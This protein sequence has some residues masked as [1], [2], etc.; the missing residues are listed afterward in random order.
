MSQHAPRTA[1]IGGGLA[2]MAAAVALTQHGLAVELFEARR[3][4][5]GRATS[6]HDAGAAEVVDHC[7]HVSMGCCTNLRDFCRRVGIDPLLRRDET[8]SFIAPDGRQYRFAATPGIPAPLHLAQGLWKLGYLSRAER[9]SIGRALLD[10]ARE[11][12]TRDD[13]PTIGDW[14][15]RHGQT[16][17]AI[18]QFWSLVLVS[19]LSETVDRAGL[20]YAR[21]VFVDGMMAHREGYTIEVPTVALD[22]LYGDSLLAW[23]ARHGARAR[24]ECP[25]TQINPA[26]D[27]RIALTMKGGAPESFDYVVLAT[28]W[29]RAAE[30]L[31]DIE[32]LAPVMAAIS[33]LEAAPITGVHLWFDRPITTL[34]HAVLVGRL[35]QWLF[36]RA[37]HAS[38]DS[39]TKSRE[40]GGHYYQVVISASRALKQ[41][42]RDTTLSQVVKDLREVFPAAREARLLRQ[43]LVTEREAVF[44][45]LPGVDRLRPAQQT[46]VDNLFLAGD[47]TATG[48]PA[49]MEGA[50][51][52]G[53]LAAE[54]L[55]ARLGRPQNLLVPDL[56]PSWIMRR[57]TGRTNGRNSAPA[58]PAQ[59]VAAPPPE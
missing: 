20:R 3:S 50:V 5:G 48:W 28:P 43:R 17:R 4:L 19:A 52:G 25:V 54:A 10:L 27:G 24:M 2:G 12:A 34:P 15:R 57:L 26:A 22:Q 32:P 31:R 1:V 35:S 38:E 47:W 30:L 14:L 45:P 11:P 59:I 18:E 9:L 51:R 53:Y 29:R 40:A 16:E 13:E 58:D 7:Q 41:Q 36:R 33:R 21:K 49:T 46:P 55:L 44:S 37:V 23:F 39:M 8:L 56:P 6:Y 42:D